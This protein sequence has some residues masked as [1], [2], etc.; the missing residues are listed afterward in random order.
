[1]PLR[2]RNVGHIVDSEVVLTDERLGDI[3]AILTNLE[4]APGSDGPEWEMSLLIGEGVSGRRVRIS[5]APFI[6][7][8]EYEKSFDEP[9]LLVGS[10]TSG[11]R[12]ASTFALFRDRFFAP[13]RDPKGDKE[14]EELVLRVKRAVY[15]EDEEL[16][17]L[18]SYVSNIEAALEFRK[19]G[20][21]RT[22][23]PDDVKLL[24]WTRDGGACVR[25][26]SKEKLHF[27]HIIPVAKGGSNVAENVQILCEPCNLRKSDK[28]GI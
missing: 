7:K 10:P 16:S 14:R 11:S 3:A 12:Q 22:T 9:F 20:P 25:C 15:K 27:D 8:T 2:V 24:V 5:L 13:D 23:I 19:D 1:M 4:P 6:S 28:I 21:Q 18:R 17:S 26:G